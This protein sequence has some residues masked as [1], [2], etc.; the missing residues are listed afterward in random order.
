[1][2][3]IVFAV[4]AP[5]L[6]ASNWPPSP[7][8]TNQVIAL[9][10]WGFVAAFAGLS[11]GHGGLRNKD[12]VVVLAALA[13]VIVAAVASSAGAA[14][15][16]GI[17]VGFAAVVAAAATVVH[18]GSVL[19]AD[20]AGSALKAFLWG[21]LL[22][23]ALSAGLGLIQVFVPEWTD[24]EWI[25]RSAPPARAVGNLRQPNH[26]SSLL[27][28]SMIALVGLR[29]WRRWPT[30]PWAAA[31][32]LLLSL[33]LVLTGSR[34]GV[35]GVLMLA[36][37]ALADR[38]MSRPSRLA[39]L[40]LPMLY[41]ALAY[42]VS[43]W[44][45][46]IGHGVGGE[47]R[48]SFGTGGDISSS[49]F[50]I[51]SNALTMIAREPWT[52]VGFGEF[53]LAWTLTEF[54]YRPTAFFDHT[55]NL[56]LQLLVELGIPVGS[57]VMVLL[58]IALM[59]AGRRA[60]A[61]Q[62]NEGM[63]RRAAFMMVLMIGLHSMLEYPLWYAYFLLPT[64]FAWG[65]ALSRPNIGDGVTTGAAPDP[66]AGGGPPANRA[67]AFAGLAMTIGSAAVMLDYWRVVVIYDP[68]ERAAP[69]E[70]RVERGQRSPLFGHHADYAAATAFGEP[71]AP[72]SASQ[73]LAF[74]RA[75]HQLL[76]VRLMIAWAQAL[77]AQGEMDK[78]RWLAARI[79]EF[80]NPG[81]D[82]FFAPCQ[83]PEQAAQAFQCQPP[84]RVVDWREFTQPR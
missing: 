48:M 36:G 43:S 41:A 65:F 78:A 31:P 54:P 25:A 75:P 38:R 29:E 34:T 70:E 72:L 30:W 64:A 32:W 69:L 15:P 37:W 71:K 60:W 23:G 13:L 2:A 84:Q 9:S 62:G 4:L 39:L 79:R 21:L 44:S 50:A 40:A 80:R 47:G 74:R 51:W 5:V 63:A 6:L 3:G 16:F 22:A 35:L 53:N 26:L 7:T 12:A 18:L 1:V 66:P 58:L 77:A 52:G 10:T 33:A 27:L 56:P 14:L 55:H 11:S 57:L 83:Q 28:W 67:L 82:E 68:P 46:A 73:Q 61:S 17:A 59:Q 49:R 45:H 8:L 24:G 42:G 19:P 81:A 76:D 20:N